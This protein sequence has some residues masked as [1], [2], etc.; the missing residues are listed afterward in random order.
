[1]YGGTRHSTATALS[2]HLTPE[3]IKRGTMH[4]TNKA[5][6]RYFQGKAQDALMVYEKISEVRTDNKVI[7]LNRQFEKSKLLK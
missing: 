7:T 4:K 3:Q 5:F 6:E 2:K 1:M